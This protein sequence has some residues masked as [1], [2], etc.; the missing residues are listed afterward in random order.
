MV[1]KLPKKCFDLVVEMPQHFQRQVTQGDIMPLY[2]QSNSE[3]E[4]LLRDLLE[5]K[6]S[7]SVVKKQKV[8]H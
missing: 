7:F 1:A 5:E 2:G 6:I 8:S 4:Q 3:K